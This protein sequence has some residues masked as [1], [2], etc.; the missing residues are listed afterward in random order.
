MPNDVLTQIDELHA[1]AKEMIKKDMA[2]EKIIAALME[3]GIKASYAEMII[4][5]VRKDN[6]D[7]I[8]SYKLIF[9]GSFFIIAGLLINYLSY[10]MAVMAIHFLFI[11]FGE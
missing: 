4:Y 8:D 6:R 1:L 9:M 2:D 3:H 7:R 11:F 5:N 10:Q